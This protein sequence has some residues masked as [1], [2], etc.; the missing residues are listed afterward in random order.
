VAELVILA[1]IQGRRMT[2]P[3]HVQAL[4]SMVF[5][6]KSQYREGWDFSW[7]GFANLCIERGAALTSQMEVQS[8]ETPMDKVTKGE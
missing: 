4:Q 3:T 2:P 7:N 8:S 1:E 5:N 6:L